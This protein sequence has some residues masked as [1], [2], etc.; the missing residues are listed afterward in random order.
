MLRPLPFVFALAVA[1]AGAAQ[2]Q[3]LP[4]EPD[5]IALTLSAED[6]VETQTAKVTARVD[7][8]L[9]GEQ[10]GDARG[11]ALRA[12]SGA[13]ED[14]VWRIT[15]FSRSQDASGL[16]RFAITAETRLPEAQLSGLAERAEEGSRPGLRARIVNV[17]FTPT[18]A[19]RE[20]K[21]AEL[22]AKLYA[23][24]A[25]ELARIN[26]AYDDRAYRIRTLTVGTGGAPPPMRAVARS[27]AR[28]MSAAADAAP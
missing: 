27:Q 15:A 22:R 28:E 13:A 24:V 9:A 10:A 16:E 2:A 19:E 23:D 20:A 5:T 1:V 3:T 17:D 18:R 6:W 11:E 7:A 4:P 14:A 25:A 8:T 21:L 12:L 26:A